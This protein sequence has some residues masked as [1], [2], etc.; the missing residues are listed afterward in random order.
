VRVDLLG[1]YRADLRRMPVA[2]AVRLHDEFSVPW[3]AITK[4]CPAPSK[5]RFVG[6]DKRLFEP[7]EDGRAVWVM[8]ACCVDPERPEEIECLDPMAVVATGPLIDL[9]AFHP[10]R[11]G[12]FALRIGNAAVLGA[13]EP[14]YLDPDCVPVWDDIAD[15]LRDN[16][17]GIVLLTNDCH[18]K[19][20]ILRRLWSIEAA[21]P[22]SVKAWIGLP[23]YPAP[24]PPA[25]FPM[26]AA[27]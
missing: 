14:Q 1:E 25:V 6:R 10:A 23:E 19:G 15:W 18:Q 17:R 4:A 2:E 11:R 9:V 26:P 7:D 27:T 22:D 21:Q 3:R 12:R 13:V 16:C 24:L 5:A 8:P 20:R